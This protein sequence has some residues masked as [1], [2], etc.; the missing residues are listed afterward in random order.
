MTQH[1]NRRILVVDDNAAI[2]ADF[3]KVLV[4]PAGDPL[5]ALESELFGAATDE[6]SPRFELE[7]AL[8]GEAGIELARAALR[9]GRPF[10]M[11]FVDVRMPPGIDGIETTARMLQ[12]DPDLQVVI[13]SAYSDHSWTEIRRRLGATDRVLI[14]RKP[15]DGIEIQ[16]LAHSLTAKWSLLQRSRAFTDGE[17]RDR[18]QAEDALRASEQRHRVLFDRS[19]LPIWVIDRETLGLRAVND[20]M[21]ALIGFSRAELLEMT[22]TGLQPPDEVEPMLRAIA[23]HPR[24]IVHMGVKQHRCK[25]GRVTE[26]DLTSHAI[27]MDGRPCLLTIGVD[28]SHARRVEE[29]LRQAHKME[30]IGQLAGGVAHD[31]N[32][33]LA[34]ILLNTEYLADVLGPSH[35]AAAEVD[36]ITAAAERG[37][38]LTRQLLA[39]SRKQQHQ[40]KQVVLNATVTEVQKML[41]RILGEDVE[42]S[43]VLAPRLGAI[44]ADPGQ[45]EQV[46]LNLAINARDA[47][48]NGGRL[49]IE[50]HNAELDALHAE[51]VGIPP[52]SYVVLSVSDTG[53]GMDAATKARIFE[54]FFTTKEVGKGTG[55]GL[56]NVFG[57]VAQGNGGIT[58]YTEPGKGTTFRMYFPR[59]AELAP[60]RL[61]DTQAR[62]PKTGSETILVVEDDEQVR[63]AIRRMLDSWGYQCLEA[64][65]GDVALDFL[66]QSHDLIDLLLTDLVMPGI[67]GRALA[68]QVRKLRPNIKVLMMSGYT[69][70]AAVK[71]GSLGPG[72][73][74]VE[75]PF[76]GISLSRA[77]RGALGTDAQT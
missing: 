64:R 27:I 54:P 77:I 28:V 62:S 33:L 19:P 59:V 60:A 2:H 12:L 49:M 71:T 21:V 18:R 8:Q 34:A 20:A 25:N 65:N 24:G 16:Q 56:S 55:L 30:A 14:L 26:L 37:A 13:C 74:F 43:T 22:I 72:E 39:F 66:R 69:E 46:L 15:F 1:E 35:P 6:V 29:Q 73:A 53:C 3:C 38:R 48:P 70:H 40:T 75:K 7:S 68:G 11:A 31:F 32:N 23:A 63:F 67:D 47:M 17:V 10:A 61:S 58:V 51:Q 52:G 9:Q 45:L 36:E 57:I 44:N 76:T 50:T 4:G 5:R 41:N 42:M